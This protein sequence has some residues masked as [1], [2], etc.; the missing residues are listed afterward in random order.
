MA[1]DLVL[2]YYH[3]KN[4]LFAQRCSGATEGAA[5]CGKPGAA[6]CPLGL[7]DCLVAAPLM[8]L[9]LFHMGGFHG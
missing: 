6:V 1:K 8:S 5:L 9:L 2:T 3:G 7:A 4:R